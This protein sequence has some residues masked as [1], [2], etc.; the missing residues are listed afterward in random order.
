MLIL[1][2]LLWILFQSGTCQDDKLN[3]P[4]FLPS[5]FILTFFVF[6]FFPFL[7]KIH[8]AAHQNTGKS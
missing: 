2:F 3:K 6:C 5:T 8:L 4:S 1:P 7:G